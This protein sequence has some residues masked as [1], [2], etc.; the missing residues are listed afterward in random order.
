MEGKETF[1]D[2]NKHNSSNDYYME[3]AGLILSGKVTDKK[4]SE[5]VSDAR[6]ILNTPDTIINILYSKTDDNGRFNFVLS[7]FYYDKELYFIVDHGTVESET[8]IEVDDKFL[9]ESSYDHDRFVLSKEQF[10]FI[11]KSQDI[12]TVNRAYGFDYVSETITE[13]KPES[14]PSVMFSNARRV[15]YPGNFVPLDSLPEISRE[16]VHPWRIRLRDGEYNSSLICAS[17]GNR[18]PEPPVYFLDGIITY[19]INKL[20]HLDSKMIEKIQVHNYPWMYGEIYFPGIIGIFTKNNEY[21]NI[22]DHRKN[23]SM[24]KESISEPVEFEGPEYKENKKND[25]S[26]PD[27]RVVLHWDNDV[28]INKGK[29][30]NINFFAGDLKG[31]YYI[32][33]QGIT[34]E[35]KPV[36][37][38]KPLKIK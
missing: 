26:K 6:V 14:H 21:L 8:I 37:I 13:K 25:Y 18:F 23:T 30:K 10:D 16:I 11:K 20:I 28:T 34:S 7:D 9:H 1:G 22:L 2:N 31:D 35:G 33:L 29:T 12:L 36:N 19:D 4:S 27:L 32:K 24:L 15:I 3:T 17:T 5:P 38:N